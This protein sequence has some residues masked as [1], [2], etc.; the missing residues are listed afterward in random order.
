VSSNAQRE[1][2]R[3]HVPRP[4]DPAARLRSVVQYEGD[5]EVHL[6][7]G[8]V[9]VL[10]QDVL[11]L[12]PRALST[13]RNVLL[14]RAMPSLTA[15]SHPSEEVALISVTVATNGRNTHVMAPF[16]SL[17]SPLTLPGEPRG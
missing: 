1:E 4:F 9:V 13:F 8:D 5:L 15:A 6:V 11:V 17:R 2:G 10:D 3:G 16:T 12:D 7:A 14:A